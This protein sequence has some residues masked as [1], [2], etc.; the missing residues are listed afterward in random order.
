MWTRE[1]IAVGRAAL[2]A[3]IASGAFT[4]SAAMAVTGGNTNDTGGNAGVTGSVS[5]GNA[6][7]SG[8]PATG[9]GTG[10][11]AAGNLAPGS[12]GGNPNASPAL[13]PGSH[14]AASGKA[15][16]TGTKK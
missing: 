12:A 2:F 4:G 10:G 1:A 14:P 13:T 15:S 6:A 11:G 3:G 16:G 9:A 5:P 8:N 7:K